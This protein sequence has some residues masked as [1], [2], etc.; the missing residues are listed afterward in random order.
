MLV[1]RMLNRGVLRLRY[2]Q[3]VVK[4]F[5]QLRKFIVR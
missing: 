4:S 5:K 2:C 1:L 3:L